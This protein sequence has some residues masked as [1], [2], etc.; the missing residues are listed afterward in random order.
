MNDKL[1]K[2]Q[3][4]AIYPLSPMQKGLLFHSVYSDEERAYHTQAAWRLQ[5]ALNVERFRSAWQQVITRHPVLRTLFLWEELETPRQVVLKPEAIELPWTFEDWRALSEHEQKQAFDRFIL[6]EHADGFAFKKAPLLRLRLFQ[7][8]AESYYFFFS[9]HHIILD[10]WSTSLL[11]NEVMLSYA[12]GALKFT[13]VPPFRDYIAWLQ[14][15]DQQACE[16]YWRNELSDLSHI[17]LPFDR[18][19]NIEKTNASHQELVL[20]LDTKL[21]KQL[22]SFTQQ[23]SITL[24]TMLQAS[25]ALLLARICNTRDLV[26]GI[27]TSG[28]PTDLDAS[29]KMIGIFI[30]TLPLRVKINPT[31]TILNWLKKLQ[32]Q[33]LELRQYEYSA[34]SQV[35]EWCGQDNGQPL[36]ESILVF[37]NF[38]MEDETDNAGFD[39]Q[40]VPLS[41]AESKIIAKHTA[42]RNHYPLTLIVVPG[43]QLQLRLAF[44]KA[45]FSQSRINA[46]MSHLQRLLYV[47]LDR[48]TWCLGDIGLEDHSSLEKEPEADAVP[49]DSLLTAFNKQLSEQANRC[50]LIDR[51]SEMDWQT[52]TQQSNRISAYLRS[53]NI[54]HESVVALLM[55]RSVHWVSIMLGILKAG[56]TFLPLDPQLPSS[57]IKTC[58]DLSQADLLIGEK[59]STINDTPV[60]TWGSLSKKIELLSVEQPPIPIFAQQLAYLIYTSGSSGTPK[61]VAISHQN[62]GEYVRSI[63]QTLDLPKQAC[64]AWASSVGADLG[65]TSVFVALAGGHQLLIIDDDMANDAEQIAHYFSEHQVDMLKIAPTHL[66][67]LLSASQQ[68]GAILPNHTLVL[69]GES[70][71]PELVEQLLSMKPN[72]RIYNHYGPTEATIGV[73]CIE[74]HEATQDQILPVG[75]PLPHVDALILDADCNFLPVDVSGELYLGGEGLARG[76][77]NQPALTAECFMPHPNKQGTRIYRTGDRLVKH[78][79]DVMYFLGRIDPQLTLNGF[80]IEPG[81]IEYWLKSQAGVEQAV[82]VLRASETGDK[83]CACLVAETNV[84]L[85]TVKLKSTLAQVLPSY[86]VPSQWVLIDTLPLT[87]NG[88]L[89]RARLAVDEEMEKS[90]NTYIAPRNDYEKQLVDIWQAVL[91]QELI[92]VEDDF[93]A[94]GGDSILSLQIIAWAR[95]EGMKLTPKQLFENP[96]IAV[97]ASLVKKRESSAATQIKTDNKEAP[98]TPIQHWFFEQQ[99][100]NR[101]HWNQSLL[102]SLSTKFDISKL[103]DIVNQL[104]SHHDALRLRFKKTSSGWEQYVLQSLEEAP[105][106][107]I[108]TDGMSAEVR[109]KTISENCQQTQQNLHLEKGPM[110]RILYFYSQDKNDEALF[111]CA[112]HLIVDTVSWR[113]L[114]NDLARLSRNESLDEKSNS[115][116][117]WAQQ[118]RHYATSD[119]LASSEKYW[120]NLPCWPAIPYDMKGSNTE[121][122][123]RNHSVQLDKAA[124]QN[125]LTNCPRVLRTRIDE[126]ILTAVVKAM[127]N[128]TDCPGIIVECESHGREDLFD[129]IDVSST[130]GW[131]TSRY[132]V[133]LIVDTSLP[134]LQQILNVKKLLREVPDNGI[135]YGILRYLGKSNIAWNEQN[136]AHLTY[137]YLGQIDRGVDESFHSLALDMGEQRDPAS[138][139]QVPLTLVGHIADGCLTLNWLYSGAQFHHHTIQKLADN[140]WTELNKLLEAVA[141]SENI[142]LSASDFPLS[143][144]SQLQLQALSKNSQS[145]EDIYPLTPL[146]QGLLFH[147]LHAPESSAYINQLSGTLNNLKLSIFCDIWAELMQRHGILRTSVHWQVTGEQGENMD[148]PHQVVHQQLAFPF[149]ELDWRSLSEKQLES[150]WQTF[151]R[152]DVVAGFELSRA[153]LWRITLIQVDDHQYRF[154][155]CRHHLLMDGWCSSKLLTE[156]VSGYE[157]TCQGQLPDRLTQS[158]FSDYIAWIKNQNQQA[159]QTFWKTQLSGFS[160]P[161]P[162][163]D[164]QLNSAIAETKNASYALEALQIDSKFVQ[165]FS[166]FAQSHQLTLNTL[167]QGAW[168][169]LLAQHSGESEVLFGVT[170]SGRPAELEGMESMMGLFINTLPL[171]IAIGESQT[172]VSWLKQLQAQ[173]SEL[174]QYEYCSLTEIQSCSEIPRNQAMFDSIVV[175]ENYPID[176][177]LRTDNPILQVSEVH[178]HEWTHYPLTLV[179][180]P[181]DNVR[182]ELQYQTSNYEPV[183][184]RRLLKQY[185]QIL[186]NLVAD[187]QSSL[188]TISMLG[189]AEYQTLLQARSTVLHPIT[190]NLVSRFET[191]VQQAP[192]AIAV[193]FEQE[194]LSYDSLNK[195]ANQLAYSLIAQGVVAESAVGLSCQPSLNLIVGILGI[196]KAGAYYVPLDPR[197]PPKRLGTIVADAG[198]RWIVG[199]GTEPD[200]NS[201]TEEWQIEYIADSLSWVSLDSNQLSKFKIINPEVFILPQQLAYVIYTSG[202]TGKP[203]G[204]SIHHAQVLRLFSACEAHFEFTANDIWSL[205][206]VYSFDVSVFELWGAL[207][208]GGQVVVVSDE[209][210]RLP[211]V[212]AELLIDKKVTVLSQTPSAFY[213]LSEVL[214]NTQQSENL[215]LRYVIFAGEALETSRLLPWF[216]AYGEQQPQLI[217]MYGTTETTVHANYRRLTKIDAEQ[218][219]NSDIG[220]PLNNL[221]AYILDQHKQLLSAGVAGELFIGGSGVGRGYYGYPDITAERFIPDPYSDFIGARLYKTGDK[222]VRLADG[223][224]RYLGRLDQQVQLRGFR[225]ELA[226]I[227]VHL[228]KISNVDDAVVLLREDV[229]VEPILVAYIVGKVDEEN[230]RKELAYR[231][232]DYMI[233]GRYVTINSLPLTVNGKLNRKAL[234]RPDTEMITQE[235]VEPNTKT[236]QKLVAIWVEVLGFERIGVSDDFFALGGHSL[237]AVQVLSRIRNTFSQTIT[238]KQLF[239]RTTIAEQAELIDEQSMNEAEN[240]I[241]K[242]AVLLDQIEQMPEQGDENANTQ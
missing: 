236:E 233:P 234:P 40:V 80:R 74:I 128:L 119:K 174:R 47:M 93:F 229:G 90:S 166:H 155:W 145:I 144:L 180:I 2:Q 176:Q 190:D 107:I 184:L 46:L 116:Q 72:L 206:H 118:L 193:C 187:A 149:V 209:T 232:P 37:D 211:D 175:F 86:M 20:T 68:S 58:L 192:Q 102:L 105:L 23:H 10:G 62:I 228:R 94:L 122:D 79:N 115:Y 16:M 97:L 183:F 194:I 71:S 18:E 125:L 138:Q 99:V 221:Q 38:P 186:E 216:K 75:C 170:V 64:V 201:F 167:F 91:K 222:A 212:F 161:T 24:N 168:A 12:T 104:I 13:R 127:A 240:N 241:D 203:K 235:Y 98:L 87:A 226:E 50:A 109:D 137:N 173:N 231:L 61:A 29:N 132:P 163:P 185:R 219:Q 17:S 126:V 55:P 169:L 25:W 26:F 177:V 100:P 76:Y 48:P 54:R 51:Q 60:I 3:I 171:R 153:P 147:S 202:S 130:V 36:F 45:H 108:C 151:L 208:Y 65:Y 156:L 95:R 39:V 22:N 53:Q 140:T 112:H 9:H 41:E 188:A 157:K 199:E 5:G 123:V 158:P 210:R 179:V 189:H 59:V 165:G 207:L 142:Y 120:T 133:A 49:A 111:I 204:V 134:L 160:V 117:Q 197:Q 230:L 73:S 19:V 148:V 101:Q 223:S 191:R 83:L 106:K 178:S 1:D 69:G 220:Q 96:T 181:N 4:E 196:L 205:F 52:L 110:L 214:L 121:S 88:K 82:V 78:D 63:S 70:L 135:G 32:A 85:D 136:Q 27:T 195:R 164:T 213:G 146:Q 14:A 77:F 57:R 162:L 198:V 67:A 182:V 150:K 200:I 43:A 218:P 31:I 237:L 225:I 239:E 215:S 92:G 131:F 124:T 56:A 44:S 35:Q 84:K 113:I 159:A 152:D 217:N 141:Q 143:N 129:S 21:S 227:E 7:I 30:N 6:T 242:I 11:L 103:T 15:Q 139:R 172:V 114:L 8:N 238:L 28:R 81:E 154:S 42:E 66:Q 89:D 34:L 224:L 33:N